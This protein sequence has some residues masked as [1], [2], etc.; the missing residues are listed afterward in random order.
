M[1]CNDSSFFLAYADVIRSDLY[2][3]LA[4]RG[5]AKDRDY[6]LIINRFDIL[7]EGLSNDPK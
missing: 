6:W 5:R 3:L 1:T 7:I 2:R 4:K